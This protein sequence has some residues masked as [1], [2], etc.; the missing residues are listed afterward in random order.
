MMALR[1]VLAEELQCNLKGWGRNAPNFLICTKYLEI[2]EKMTFINAFLGTMK[3]IFDRT[4]MTTKIALKM[5]EM[6]VKTDC[7]L[8]CIY[9]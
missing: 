9:K 3:K 4:F 1:T 7:A 2:V 5:A 6:A 8:Y